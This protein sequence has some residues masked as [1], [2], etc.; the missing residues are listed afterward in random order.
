MERPKNMTESADKCARLE[1]I[2]LRRSPRLLVRHKCVC[3]RASLYIDHYGFTRAGMC[4]LSVAFAAENPRL[5]DQISR[6][7]TGER[8][9]SF[10]LNHFVSTQTDVNITF[11][12]PWW[13]K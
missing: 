3:T 7:F 10:I 11:F 13:L 5:A 2:M 12:V 6:D 4:A 1:R 8:M 9:L